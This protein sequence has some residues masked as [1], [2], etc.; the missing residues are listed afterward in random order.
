[1]WGTQK[2]KGDPDRLNAVRTFEKPRC[3]TASWGSQNPME[4]WALELSLPAEFVL[5]NWSSANFNALEYLREKRGPRAWRL[6]SSPIGA[7]D[8]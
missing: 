6:H 1:M 5:R 4:Q 2:G 3:L 7:T 8:I